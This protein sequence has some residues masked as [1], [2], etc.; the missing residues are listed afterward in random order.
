MINLETI[1]IDEK[2]RRVSPGSSMGT[3][4]D[5]VTNQPNTTN[6]NDNNKPTSPEDLSE[7]EDDDGDFDGLSDLEIEDLEQVFVDPVCQITEES[8]H[9]FYDQDMEG[10]ESY[11][12]EAR[13][14]TGL[15]PTSPATGSDDKDF[16]MKKWY[17]HYVS[18]KPGTTQ[19]MAEDR[20]KKTGD[21]IKQPAIM[22]LNCNGITPGKY[23]VVLCV[24]LSK[25][26]CEELPYLNVRATTRTS[27]LSGMEWKFAS[28]IP[29][30]RLDVEFRYKQVPDYY[31]CIHYLQLVE[32]SA[33]FDPADMVVS[34]DCSPILRLWNNSGNL[35]HGRRP[36]SRHIMEVRAHSISSNGE[37]LVTYSVITKPSHGL[38]AYLDVWDV[39]QPL[40]VIGDGYPRLARGVSRDISGSNPTGASLVLD[41][42]DL[43]ALLNDRWV[44]AV[45][46]MDGS[47]VALISS[48]AENSE[49]RLFQLTPDGTFSKDFPR[50]PSLGAFCGF[51][52]FHIIDGEERFVACHL[53]PKKSQGDVK[54]TVYDCP[55]GKPWQPWQLQEITLAK[56]EEGVDSV[57]EERRRGRNLEDAENFIRSLQGPFAAWTGHPKIVST[58]NLSTGR[59]ISHVHLHAGQE[60]T[61]NHVRFSPDGSKFVV[62]NVVPITDTREIVI[63]L[64]STESGT[65]VNDFGKYE[66]PTRR[67]VID[68]Y[69][70]KSKPKNNSLRSILDTT[71][72]F[73]IPSADGLSNAYRVILNQC[74]Q[75]VLVRKQGSAVRVV[76]LDQRNSDVQC[77]STFHGYLHQE[78]PIM[79]VKAGRAS[80]KQSFITCQNYHET[81]FKF[82]RKPVPNRLQYAPTVYELTRGT[83]EGQKVLL[84]FSCRIYY[85]FFTKGAEDLVCVGKNFVAVWNLSGYSTGTTDEYCR[86]MQIR[87]F[88]NSIKSIFQPLS[89]WSNPSVTS[90]VTPAGPTSVSTAGPTSE[91]A[92]GLTSESFAG[93]T[94]EST[95]RPTL[96]STGISSTNATSA[97]GHDKLH[98][99]KHSRWL[100]ITLRDGKQRLLDLK[101][102]AIFDEANA[103][104]F[105]GGISTLIRMDCATKSRRRD[106]LMESKT[107]HR[108]VSN[109]I[110]RHVNV[111]PIPKQPQ[112]SVMATLC[113]GWR[114]E[115]RSY[116]KDLFYSILREKN[117]WAPLPLSKYTDESNPIAI[118]L[119]KGNPVVLGSVRNLC[120]YCFSRTQKIVGG[121]DG[122]D[123]RLFSYLSPVFHSMDLLLKQHPDEGRQYLGQLALFKATAD[124]YIR[125]NH[126]IAYPPMV[127]LSSVFRYCLSVVFPSI[128]QKYQKDSTDT[129]SSNSRLQYLPPI[130]DLARPVLILCHRGDE[131]NYQEEVEDRGVHFYMASPCAMWRYHDYLK[132]ESPTTTFGQF[133]AF[134][135]HFFVPRRK[136]YIEMNRITIKEYNNPYMMAVIQYGWYT[137]GFRYWLFRFVAQVL[138]YGLILGTV[139]TQGHRTNNEDLLPAIA[140]MLFA[141][142]VF[143]SVCKFVTILKFILSSI[144]TYLVI[145][146]LGIL[147]FAV[148]IQHLVGRYDP[149]AE[150]FG[151]KSVPFELFLV[152][153]VFAAVIIMLNV[154]IALMQGTYSDAEKVWPLEWFENRLENVENA[155][156]LEYHYSGSGLTDGDHIYPDTIYYGLTH[157]ERKKYLSEHPELDDFWAT[158]VA[159]NSR[160]KPPDQFDDT[161]EQRILN[162]LFQWAT[163]GQSQLGSVWHKW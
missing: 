120:D 106:K 152:I 149:T 144:K 6:N 64:Y 59:M 81:L 117:K 87:E 114:P 148:A 103:G 61:E 140:I 78:L 20:W 97:P 141:L 128:P 116:Y 4:Q 153:Y 130:K 82:S 84:S 37:R 60:W 25:A 96:G 63:A 44:R 92:T 160:T 125:N 12:D 151:A 143:R 8:D 17:F 42:G 18:A 3:S 41:F 136:S 27:S 142:R 154:L 7:D 68:Q 30:K 124:L 22:T 49:F 119:K 156:N 100:M 127:H 53:P 73:N 88:N 1:H 83:G 39:T 38:V 110:S 150:Q 69:Q 21:F 108:M 52:E 13:S 139:L 40:D 56:T 34:Q 76:V 79:Q 2:S 135:G 138:Y 98:L 16:H 126:R 112:V 15:P 55:K 32:A 113:E 162:L 102:E 109:Y 93:P 90:S 72:E 10:D 161:S 163:G 101:A 131:S 14:V 86:L 80:T 74:K 85:A 137:W 159:N 71:K 67:T 129:H 66:S 11:N 58:W 104:E 122:R 123:A 95:V 5:I 26:G 29:K 31:L 57:E 132:G 155:L 105:L 111:Y 45:I 147:A 65:F 50:T 94:S 46:S 36:D 24:R 23:W 107:F 43:S 133:W 19:F 48:T 157:K 89:D 158:I 91:T 134:L 146:I 47:R 9:D 118:L 33:I 145:F 51:G 75:L 35:H 28:E 62:Y 70:F 77:P 99:C 115:Y 121:G 54:V